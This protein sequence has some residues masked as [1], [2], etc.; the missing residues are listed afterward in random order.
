MWEGTPLVSTILGQT[1][2]LIGSVPELK[3]WYGP[4]FPMR[5]NPFCLA[6]PIGDR[7]RTPCNDSVRAYVNGEVSE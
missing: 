7:P 1:E 5:Q 4:G 6:Y 3:E 2:K